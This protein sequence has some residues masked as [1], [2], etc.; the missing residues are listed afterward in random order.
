M[1]KKTAKKLSRKAKKGLKVF[2]GAVLGCFFAAGS[3]GLYGYQTYEKNR[4][5]ENKEDSL[6]NLATLSQPLRLY[7]EKE[8]RALSLYQVDTVV[9]DTAFLSREAKRNGFRVYGG[10]IPEYNQYNIKY[11]VVNT[12]GMDPY[13]AAK[14]TKKAEQNNDPSQVSLISIHEGMHQDN[15]NNGLK[16]YGISNFQFAKICIHDEISAH[17]A[18]LLEMRD[19]YLRTGNISEIAP[20]YK[21]YINALKQ[22]QITPKPDEIPSEQECRLIANGMQDWWCRANQKYYEKNHTIMV[23][24]WMRRGFMHQLREKTFTG[25]LKEKH[26]R[27]YLQRLSNCYT[28]QIGVQK[29]EQTCSTVINFLN[30]MDKDVSLSPSIKEA[31]RVQS[32]YPLKVAYKEY[33]L[34]QKQLNKMQIAAARKQPLK[35]AALIKK[36]NRIVPALQHTRAE[37][38]GHNSP[39][40]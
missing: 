34:A 30:Y 26:R 36:R 10:Y 8:V 39:S 32:S 20:R 7:H 33:Q 9:I 40:R 29:G 15:Q 22:K 38:H 5:N 17:I 28:F 3:F 16:D 35:G 6:V 14:E 1:M 27:E 11:F 18:E 4:N 24:N 19:R 13:T 2:S 31:I 25:N 21:F 37:W 12:E 23:R